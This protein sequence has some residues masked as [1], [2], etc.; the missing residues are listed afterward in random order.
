MNR[1]IALVLKYK[2][3]KGKLRTYLVLN[4]CLRILEVLLRSHLTSLQLMILQQFPVVGKE[5][6]PLIID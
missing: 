3:L 6:P 5:I 1:T 2:Y 4:A